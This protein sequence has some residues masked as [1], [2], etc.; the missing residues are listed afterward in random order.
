MLWATLASL[1]VSVLALIVSFLAWRNARK[2]TALA[3]GA[4][5]YDYAI[6]L[7]V[8]DEQNIDHGSAGP[9]VFTYSAKLVNGGMKPVR[10]ERIYIDYGDKAM[11]KSVHHVIDGVS[12]IP[13]NGEREI[14]FKLSRSDYQKTLGR[15]AINSCFVRLRVRYRNVSGG[16]VEAERPLVVMGP[17]GASTVFAQRGDALT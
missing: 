4:Q 3:V 10:I 11:D 16:I 13:P 14:N 17:Y 7:Q 12:D 6:R 9:D 2:A 5:E 15:F 1:A 8:R